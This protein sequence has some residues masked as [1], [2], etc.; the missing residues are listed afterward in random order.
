MNQIN[1]QEL[2]VSIDVGCY[3]HDISVGLAN[4]DYLGHF[5]INHDKA[6]FADFFNKIEAY[7]KKS[8][9]K[10]SVAMEGYNGHARPLDQMIQSRK[11]RLLNINNLKLARF[12][13][14]FPG[15]AKSDPIDSRKGLELFQLQQ[16]LPLAKNVLQE[17][18]EVPQVNQELKRLTRRRRRLVDERVSYINTLQ[19]DLRALSPGLLEITKNVK[20]IWFLNF[21]ASVNDLKQLTS[22]SKKVLLNIKQVGLK[23]VEFILKWQKEAV[24]SSEA[25]FMSPMFKQDVLRII[26]LRKMIKAIDQQI[27][28]RLE[29]SRIGQRLLSIKGFGV[30]C[31]AELAGEVGCIERFKKESSLALYLGM[32]ALDNSS[33]K[34]KGSK[35]SR[36]VNKHAKMAMMVASDHQRRGSEQSQRY[37]EKKRLEGK[38]HNQ[39]IRSLGRHL[40][41]VIYKMLKEDRDYYVK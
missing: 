7:K 12:K 24:F 13:E 15:A 19:S 33:G 5:E 30:T 35:A 29:E 11:Y 20:N 36:Q 18:Y 32:A 37:Y 4:G 17:V 21:L 34:R 23:N 40:T 39:A 38:K 41:R 25:S 27:L 31:C 10:V 3:Q 28:L 16:T 1:S 14:I 6:G 2:H 22:K 26:E 9:G 8:N